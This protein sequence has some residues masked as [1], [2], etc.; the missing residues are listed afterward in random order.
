MQPLVGIT[1]K[2][3]KKKL[4]K[5]DEYRSD[6]PVAVQ[7]DTPYVKETGDVGF[8]IKPC[9]L[10][11]RAKRRSLAIFASHQFNLKTTGKHG[12]P[13][14]FRLTGMFRVQNKGRICFVSLQVRYA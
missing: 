9:R 4:P 1:H 2:P 6:L 5:E 11:T 14:V 8:T 3:G 12:L 10:P 7:C 13:R